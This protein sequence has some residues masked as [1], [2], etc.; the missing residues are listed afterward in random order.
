MHCLKKNVKI[1]LDNISPGSSYSRNPRR[2]AA[3]FPKPNL[4]LELG[5]DLAGR[6]ANAYA[7]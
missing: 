3:K 1:V 2:A 7:F 4:H 6:F 5:P